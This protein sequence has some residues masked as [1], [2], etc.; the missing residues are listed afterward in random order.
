MARRRQT[1]LTREGFFYLLVLLS[2]VIGAALRQLNLLILL[3]TVLTGPLAFSFFY[4]RFAL[5]NVRVARKLPA[6][7]PR[8]N[9]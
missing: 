2:V 3:G 7:L 6:M 5:R 9:V 1:R 8:I 4:G